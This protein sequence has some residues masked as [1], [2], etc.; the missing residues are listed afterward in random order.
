MA[1]IKKRMDQELTQERLD[2]NEAMAE[3]QLDYKEAKE[4]LKHWKQENVK[5]SLNDQMFLYLQNEVERK[6]EIYK[7]LVETYNE[8]IKKMPD[9]VAPLTRLDEFLANTFK[10]VEKNL[11]EPPTTG[12]PRGNP[13]SPKIVKRWEGF[14][15]DASQFHLS[16]NRD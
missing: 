9:S 6:E 5:F 14:K 13:K 10:D 1:T 15:I 4:A 7:K 3:A 12:T 11:V 8:L 2:A 16:Y